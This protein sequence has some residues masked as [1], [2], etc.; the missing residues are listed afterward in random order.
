MK[1]IALLILLSGFSLAAA[2]ATGGGHD[3][4]HVPLDK[5]GWQAANLGILL[6]LIYFGIKKSIVE[7][8]EKRRQDF[9]DQSEKTKAALV[10]A[11]NELKE[12]KT[13]MSALEAGEAKSVEN[14]KHEANL[15]KAHMIRDAETMAT[16]MKTD[17]ELSIQAELARAR[18]EINAIILK[19]AIATA[20]QKLTSTASDSAK[21]AESQFLARV[22]QANSAKASL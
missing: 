19:E 8:F 17:A 7:T 6:L 10:A 20:K 15:M 4:D 22:D 12:I 16:K 5:I 1:K 11:E 9:L 3:A 18:N 2:A 13:K 14:A 21:G